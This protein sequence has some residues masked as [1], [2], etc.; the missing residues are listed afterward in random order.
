M[1]DEPNGRVGVIGTGCDA[2]V[3]FVD[4]DDVDCVV[5]AVVVVGW[6]CVE[7]NDM[8]LL[9]PLSDVIEAVPA[10]SADEPAMFVEESPR[11]EFG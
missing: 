3:V 8:W 6:F 4:D 10:A 2:V 9:E 11:R 1:D 5:W 7:K